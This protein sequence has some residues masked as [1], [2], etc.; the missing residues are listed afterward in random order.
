MV[1]TYIHGLKRTHKRTHTRTHTHIYTR[2]HMHTQLLYIYIYNYITI[3]YNGSEV[4]RA[5]IQANR[6]RAWMTM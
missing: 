2:I 3:T 6:R 4:I 5:D 1:Y